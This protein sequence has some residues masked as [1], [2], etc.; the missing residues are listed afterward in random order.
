MIILGESLT[1]HYLAILPLN[2]SS[3]YITTIDKIME[4]AICI[5]LFVPNHMNH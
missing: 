3:M 4:L 5:E 1:L 2:N